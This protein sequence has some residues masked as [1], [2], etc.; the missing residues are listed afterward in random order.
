MNTKR[1]FR[2][3]LLAFLAVCS[4]SVQAQED[5]TSRIT[6]PSFEDGM[7]GWT[8]YGYNPENPEGERYVTVEPASQPASIDPYTMSNADGE[9]LCD[10][11]LW[12]WTGWWSFYNVS[13]TL[14]D[15][16]AGSYE[17]TAIVASHADREVTLFA[18]NPDAAFNDTNSGAYSFCESVTTT[19]RED[20]IEVHLNFY[21]PTRQDLRIGAGLVNSKSWWEVF[22]KVDNF[23][24]TY[25]GNSTTF[26]VAALNVDGLPK[27]ILNYELNS[28][29]PG[30]GGTKLISQYLAMKRYDLIG[31]SE[32]F[33][34][35]G[36]LMSSLDGYSSGKV[37]ATLSVTNIFQLLNGGIDTD[38]LNLIWNSAN[39]ITAS[40]ES[41]TKWSSCKSGEGNEYI[42]KGYRY[43]EVQLT[44]N[45]VID[46]YVLHMDAGSDTDEDIG[47][48]DSRN[49]QWSQLCNAIKENPYTSRPKLVIGDTN[50]RWTREDIW[51]RFF[52]K[53]FSGVYSPKDAWVEFA[54]KGRYGQ[55]RTD[56]SGYGWGYVDDSNL[57]D[58]RKYEVVDKIIFLNPY[59]KENTLQLEL[60][61][62]RIEQDYTYD[63]INHDG[64]TTTLYFIPKL[65]LYTSLI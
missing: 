49:E 35:H 6:N 21:L 38:G 53:Q 13:Q 24:L 8:A 47:Y 57:S 26:T 52:F 25:F 54:L 42:K 12:A 64:N 29:G 60:V 50:S 51:N 59:D 45:Q 23:R 55:A 37:R 22:F 46:V 2:F 43:Y 1:L 18:G 27:K 41:W 31:V 19:A 20:G 3:A 58:Y 16:P 5:Y 9:S 34:Y 39:G 14:A 62:F 11:Y 30:E 36:S 61:S 63:T 32:D 15:L 28:D 7:K 44:P 10:F 33:N 65:C 17:L 4:T 56:P 40:N 48:T